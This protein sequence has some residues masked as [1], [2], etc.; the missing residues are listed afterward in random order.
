VLPLPVIEM[1][2]QLDGVRWILRPHPRDPIQASERP[3]CQK[4][5]ALSHV[6]ISDSTQ[7]LLPTLIRCDLH[8]T[9]NSSVV[10]EAAAIGR[11]S[12]F[13]D[14]SYAAAFESETRS[15]LAKVASPD[16]MPELVRQALWPSTPARAPVHD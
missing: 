5:S 1:I 10:I 2:T 14:R 13:W 16:E 7:A 6:E 3:D 12:I 8:V 11:P 15:G 4:L 9:E